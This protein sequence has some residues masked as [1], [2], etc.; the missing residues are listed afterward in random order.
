MAVPPKTEAIRDLAGAAI[1]MSPEV[2][3]YYVISVKGYLDPRL[4]R[5]FDGMTI[6]PDDKLSGKTIVSG[7]LADQAALQAI[8]AKIRHLQLRIADVKEQPL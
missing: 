3:P 6:T 1:I 4:S 2:R 5:W 7:H 8:L